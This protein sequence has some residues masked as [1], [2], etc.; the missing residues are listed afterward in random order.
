MKKETGFTLIELLIGIAVLAVLLGIGVPSFQELIRTNRVAAITND[1]LAAMQFARSEAVRRGDLV[2]VCSSDDG[3][4]CSGA[5]TD[6]WVVR[7][8]AAPIR[9]WPA[10]RAGAVV[11]PTVA[12]TVVFEPVGN[13]VAERCFNVQ[14]NGAVRQV[15]VGAGGRVRS[16]TVVCP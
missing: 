1:L 2:T 10:L 4:T 14:F 11:D 6:G 7:T 9:V 13:V 8:A 15:D 16:D 12:G 5:W 3:S